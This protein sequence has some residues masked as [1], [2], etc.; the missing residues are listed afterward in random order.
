MEDLKYLIE[1]ISVSSENPLT[2]RYYLANSAEY[3]QFRIK[4]GIDIDEQIFYADV[5]MP[6]SVW[7]AEISTFRC[8]QEGYVIGEVVLDA[9]ASSRSKVD[10]VILLRISGNGVYRLPQETYTDL[11]KKLVEK[12]ENIM[13]PS[14]FIMYSNFQYCKE[15][16]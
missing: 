1:S 16:E 10:S 14:M 7:V 15:K 13:L 12:E 8:Y 2:V 11:E 5:L 6:K 4:N 3:K 9:T